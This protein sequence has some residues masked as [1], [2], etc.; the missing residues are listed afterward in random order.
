MARRGSTGAFGWLSGFWARASL[1]VLVLVSLGFLVLH[2][3][4]DT[5]PAMN[6]VRGATDDVTSP[7]MQ[8]INAPL[9][10]VRRAS[11]WLGSFW[12]S[13]R[14]VRQLE[15]EN[16][17]L[18]Q[19]E[20]LSHALHGKILRYERL[21]NMQGQSDIHAVSTRLIAESHGPF[22]RSALLRAGRNAGIIEG[23]AVVEPD[24]MIGRIVRTGA[25]TS[26]V[27]LLNDLN[28]RIPVR[29][30]GSAA[31]AIL[32]GDNQVH[33]KLIYITDAYIPPPGTRIST[34]GDDGVLPFGIAIGEVMAP[35]AADK[36]DEIRVRMFV[37]LATVDFV[38]VF[39]KPP[40]APPEA[41]GEPKDKPPAPIAQTDAKVVQ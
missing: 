8:V 39:G 24:G 26:R 12:Y 23:H 6:G 4:T 5:S 3:Q 11:D 9:N 21:L 22:V 20:S 37:N 17:N 19:W 32:A 13:A 2:N 18:R 10:G 41:E 25:F 33:P 16:R 40:V 7:A 15:Q 1:F 34:S 27:L 29:F 30:D 38:Q 28:S 36:N 14:R 35:S 31:R